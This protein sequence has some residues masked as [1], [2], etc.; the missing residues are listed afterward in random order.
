MVEGYQEDSLKISIIC[1]NSSCQK[2]SK[3][4]IDQLCIC[5][6]LRQMCW[7]SYFFKQ[8]PWK[9]FS[10]LLSLVFKRRRR[11]YLE[12]ESYS[13][14]E[15]SHA[16]NFSLIGNSYQNCFFFIWLCF[17]RIIRIMM[18]LIWASGDFRDS[19]FLLWKYILTRL[20]LKFSFDKILIP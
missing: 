17:L 14:F 1:Q 6:W 3:I 8:F 16:S 15:S 19:G 13:D 2:F 7:I 12:D 5:S 4:D 11:F 20:F 9:G 10:P 18:S